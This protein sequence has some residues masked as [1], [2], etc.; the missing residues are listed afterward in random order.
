MTEIAESVVPRFL[1]NAS[2]QAVDDGAVILL[3]DTGQLYTCNETTEAFLRRIDGERNFGAIL[4]GL[5]AEYALD[6]PTAL[7]DFSALAAE[8]AAEGIIALG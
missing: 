5:M 3:A 6:R 7:G 1:P 8:L 4:D 2:F